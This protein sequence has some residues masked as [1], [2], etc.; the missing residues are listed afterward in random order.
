MRANTQALISLPN[1]S[2]FDETPSRKWA[3]LQ[4]PSIETLLA[5]SVAHA[6]TDNELLN[7]LD[8]P[9]FTGIYPQTRTDLEKTSLAKTALAELEKA[10]ASFPQKH[11]RP[12]DFRATVTGGFWDTPSVIAGLP[13]AAR[14]RTRSKLPPKDIR[15]AL[16]LSASVET[17]DVYKVSA[18][19]VRAIHEYILAGGVVNLT[20][21]HTAQFEKKSSRGT[22]GAAVC[23]RVNT[24]N[25]ASLALAISP[26]MTRLVTGPL[27]T[28][29]SDAQGDGRYPPEKSP[30]PG[31]L[32]LGGRGAAWHA[33]AKT[34]LASLAIV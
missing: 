15:I 25:L 17:K 14:S 4:F 6:R 9:H 8:D 10:R 16:S 32:Y 20:V 18:Q 11:T 13:L 3:L 21:Y 33:A 30:V 28:A 5:H 26:T 27:I 19:I 31:V 24:A 34:V 22:I 12:G 23:A 29:L 7:A 2:E 1:Y